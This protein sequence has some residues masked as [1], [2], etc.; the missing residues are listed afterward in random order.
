MNSAMKVACCLLLVSVAAACKPP[1][2]V[3]TEGWCKR[4]EEKPRADW[5]PNDT[6][7]FTRN[8]IFDKHTDE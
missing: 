2:A 3:G 7:V 6:S 1:P 4:M 8:C 5:N